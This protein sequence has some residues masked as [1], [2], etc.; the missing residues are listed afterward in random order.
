MKSG[1]KSLWARFKDLRHQLFY[2]LITRRNRETLTLG[3]KSQW[4]IQSGSIF[5]NSVVYSAGVGGDVSFEKELIRQFGCP[6]FILDPSPTGAATMDRPENRNAKLHFEPIGLADSDG[7]FS[8]KAPEK[9]KEGSFRMTTSSESANHSFRCESLATLMRKRGHETIDL[10]KIDIEGFEYGVLRQICAQKLPVKQIC[11]EFHHSLIPG[12]KR[13]QTIRAIIRL[14]RS[15][16]RL[17]YRKNWDH[18]FAL[19]SVSKIVDRH[20]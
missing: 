3:E 17:I 4:T 15:G 13:K 7:M 18:T 9:D 11:V 8:F 16:Y 12:V 1:N 20:S 14:L 5:E 2:A 6:V 10:L 19:P